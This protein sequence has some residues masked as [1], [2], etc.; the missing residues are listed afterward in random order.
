MASSDESTIALNRRRGAFRTLALGYVVRY[1]K[2]DRGS[3]SMPQGSGI[4]FHVVTFAVESNDLELKRTPLPPQTISLNSRKRCRSSGAITS[5]TFLPVTSSAHGAP[6]IPKPERIHE[7]QCA[8]RRNDLH[9]FRRGFDDSAELFIRFHF[10]I[11][12]IRD[13]DQ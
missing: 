11:L 6:T 3:I 12:A 8:V 13:V 10:R 2:M 1:G 4:G 7:Q 9:A 5:Y